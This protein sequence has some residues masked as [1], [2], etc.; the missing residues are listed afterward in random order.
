MH[1]NLLPQSFRRRLLICRCVGV[2]S[3]IWLAC[4]VL[5]AIYLGAGYYKLRAE[6]ALLSQMEVR[7][8]PVR[9]IVSQSQKLEQKLTEAR[10]RQADL[11]RLAPSSKALPAISIVSQATRSLEGRLQL[12]RFSFQ[13]VVETPKPADAAAPASQSKASIERGQLVLEA[14]AIDDTV[15]ASFIDVLRNVPAIRQVE[16]KSSTEWN[17]T[18]KSRRRFEVICFF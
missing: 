9:L 6:R 13:H 4:A 3:L 1:V 12:R 17:A 18:G 14:V 5:C 8:Q 16:L 15:I 7:C 2:W 10:T 11:L